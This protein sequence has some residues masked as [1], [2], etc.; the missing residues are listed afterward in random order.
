MPGEGATLLR[1]HPAR[2]SRLLAA[3]GDAVWCVDL[4][5]AGVAADAF[6]PAAG[7]PSSVKQLLGSLGLERYLARFE[8]E[9]MEMPVLIALARGEGKDA[10]DA[11]LKELGV[12]SIGHRL[13]IFAALQG[14]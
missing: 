7:A 8:A 9:E 2:P 4:A 14:T 12:N 5:R 1:W 10:L 6:A 3:R 13:K 11:A